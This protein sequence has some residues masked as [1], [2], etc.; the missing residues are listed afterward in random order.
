[1]ADFWI[2]LIIGAVFTALGVGILLWGRREEKE[3]CQAMSDRTDV[4]K[5]LEYKSES[6]QSWSFRVG[7]IITLVIG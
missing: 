3:I 7:G 2:M 4:R 6:S 5:Y 1:M